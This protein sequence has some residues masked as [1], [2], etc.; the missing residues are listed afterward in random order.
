MLPV[1]SA[2]GPLI[3]ISRNGSPIVHVTTVIKGV[4][5][6]FFDALTGDYE[7]LYSSNSTPPVISAVNAV[8]N[9]DRSITVSWA[10]NEYATSRIDY[11]TSPGALGQNSST[12]ALVAFPFSYL[13]WAGAYHHVLLSRQF[14]GCCREHICVSGDLPLP[15]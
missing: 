11:G 8:L 10:T 15:H 4:E 13:G 2:A 5:Y 1:Q 12:L 14:H 6:A 3:G 7:A 9:L